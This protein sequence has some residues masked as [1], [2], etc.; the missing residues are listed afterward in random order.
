MR[1]ATINFEFVELQH[2]VS[3]WTI[4]QKEK[5]FISKPALIYNYNKY[6]VG[7][8][9]DGWLQKYTACIEQEKI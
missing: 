7:V 3:Y 8:D 4:K 9:Q 1:L 6:I 2:Q 5:V